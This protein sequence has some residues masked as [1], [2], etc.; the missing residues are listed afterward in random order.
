MPN[1]VWPGSLPSEPF[2]QGFRERGPRN[3]VTTPMEVGKKTRRRSTARRAPIDL[4]IPMDRTQF[5]AFKAFF[6]ATLGDGALPFDF[7]H[8]LDATTRTFAF[9]EDDWEAALE[10]G[11]SYVD[12]TLHLEIVP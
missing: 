5:A 6:E 4:A 11:G 10:P 2:V 7:V 1:P 12:V 8:P 9:R 3:R